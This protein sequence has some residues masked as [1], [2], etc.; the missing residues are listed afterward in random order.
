M[1][2]KKLAK[3]SK[4]HIRVHKLDSTKTQIIGF[5]AQKH[6]EET[7]INLYNKCYNV[8]A[9]SRNAKTDN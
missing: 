7:H 1:G 8:H 5:V 4:L 2:I 3:D 9:S 6:L